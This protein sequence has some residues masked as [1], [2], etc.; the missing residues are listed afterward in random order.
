MTNQFQRFFADDDFDFAART[1]I[2]HAAQ[3]TGDLG[4]V[5]VAFSQI[6][7]GN[8]VSWYNAW[9]T[10][11][12]AAANDAATALTAGHQETAA[13][14]SLTASEAYDQA[15][16]FVNGMPDDSALLP[17][18]KLHRR[19]WDDFV[20]GSAGRHL[21]V[22]VPY[23]GD[24]LPGYL[25]RPDTSGAARPTVV[26]TNGSDG[27][28]SGLWVYAIRA[29]LERGWN[30]FVF[31]GPGQQ[32][33]LFERNIPFR[34][35]W[36]AVLTPVVDCL[37]GRTDVDA[38]GLLA[39]GL[40]QGGYWLPRALAFEHRFVA[41]VADPGVMD[42]STSWF[43]NLPP[44]LLELFKAGDAATFD[45]YVATGD[46]TPQ[47]AREYA[48]RARPYGMQSA[49]AL[50]S[51]VAKYTLVGVTDQITTPLLIMDPEN[52]SFWPGQSQQLFDALKGEKELVNFTQAQGADYHCE[53]L[54][55]GLASLRMND[56]FA[57]HLARRRRK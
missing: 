20:A 44:P 22:A 57:D 15:L 31:D 26:V 34:Y 2:G 43:K 42:V 3:G 5:L 6:E 11:A 30:A 39:Y 29:S 12:D 54:G 49:F 9:R 23:Q 16:A 7:N 21:P 51:E 4:P 14:F 8:S 37:V 32:S 18:F 40:S 41:A 27:A 13:A 36:E 24:T 35:D 33:M 17:T 19:C 47:Q 56:F 1:A 38:A 45:K 50:F 48:F 25:F 10:V 28:L 52:E 46:A 53:P 55:R